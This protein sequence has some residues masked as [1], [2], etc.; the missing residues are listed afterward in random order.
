[1]K[2]AGQLPVVYDAAEH[3]LG[4]AAGYA[5]AFDYVFSHMIAKA[6]EV[7]HPSAP[8]MRQMGELMVS[9]A[10]ALLADVPDAEQQAAVFKEMVDGT[11]S[12]KFG[13]IV[14]VDGTTVMISEKE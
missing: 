11:N 4:V 14:A 10:A 13:V 9:A 6:E 1:M 3:P 12:M 7:S 5:E 8:F 2:E